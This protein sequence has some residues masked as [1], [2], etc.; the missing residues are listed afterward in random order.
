MNLILFIIQ[1][2]ILLT[3]RRNNRLF[4]LEVG[5]AYFFA[6]QQSEFTGNKLLRVS[7]NNYLV[8]TLEKFKSG[9]S[10]FHCG[11]IYSKTFQ[12]LQSNLQREVIDRFEFESIFHAQMV[13]NRYYKWYNEKRR[14]GSLNRMTPA[15]HGKNII[16]ALLKI[17]NY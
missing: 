10:R 13:I 7:H 8:G 3:C 1:E 5:F 6:L 9:Y 16:R 2:N 4:Y 11:R 12:A 15:T 17:K 14:H